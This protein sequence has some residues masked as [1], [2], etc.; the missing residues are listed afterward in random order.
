[1]GPPDDFKK[2]YVTNKIFFCENVSLN[3]IDN[4]VIMSLIKLKN[5]IG[6]YFRKTKFY[7]IFLLK[8]LKKKYWKVKDYTTSHYNKGE[9]YQVHE[10]NCAWMTCFKGMH[11]HNGPHS[12][13]IN[14]HEHNYTNQYA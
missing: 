5:F 1:M 10:A 13:L 11:K 3:D 7:A 9:D 6:S 2:I 4:F 14:Y 12:H 8:P